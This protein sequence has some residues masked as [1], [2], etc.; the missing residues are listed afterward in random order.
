[1][2]PSPMP[3]AT[4]SAK[5]ARVVHSVTKEFLPSGSQYWPIAWNI[6]DGAGSTNVSILKMRQ[7]SSHSTNMPTVNSQGESLS[8]V[9]FM[10]TSTLRARS[11][12]AY[13]GD[14]G[15]QLMH[16]VGELRLEADVEIARPRQIDSFRHNNVSGPRTHDVNVIGKERRFAQIMRHQDDGKTELLP[17][18]AQH[19][20]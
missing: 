20:P 2:S 5:P 6:C 8:L 14:L 15:P 19:A 9:V 18:I 3:N 16:D 1:M 13:L 7:A 4:A 17:K 11:C 10:A 12:L